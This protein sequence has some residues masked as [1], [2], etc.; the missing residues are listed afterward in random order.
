MEVV[1]DRLIRSGRHHDDI[2]M[3]YLYIHLYMFV[4]TNIY[5]RAMALEECDRLIRSR[6]HHDDS[7]PMAAEEVAGEIYLSHKSYAHM[8]LTQE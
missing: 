3:I 5:N 7:R 6:R 8:P 4:Y 1:G 2:L